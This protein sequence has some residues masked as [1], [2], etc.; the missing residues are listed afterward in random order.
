MALL[1][2]IAA[3]P[4]LCLDTV[5][6]LNFFRTERSKIRVVNDLETITLIW[7][8][9]ATRSLMEAREVFLLALS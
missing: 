1:R 5:Y 7:K 4:H 2:A 3:N 6:T 9:I 8:N